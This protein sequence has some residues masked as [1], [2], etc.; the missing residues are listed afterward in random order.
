MTG[1]IASNVTSTGQVLVLFVLFLLVLLG[2]SAIGIDYAA[3]LLTDRNLQNTADHAALA[4][5]S[6]FDQ[7]ISQGSCSSGPGVA[8]CLNARAQAWTSLVNEL[9]I[10]D[11][12]GVAIGGA[13][14]G[15]L[16][17]GNSP[18]S[19]QA[20]GSYAGQPITFKDKIWVSTPPPTYDAY[21]GVGGRYALNYGVVFV[22][23]DRAVP[24]FLGGALGISPQPRHG[25]AT[26]GALPTDFALEVFCRNHIAPQSGVCVNSAGLALDGAGVMVRLRRGDIGSNESLTITSNVGS[27]VVVE[28]GNMFLVNRNCGPSTWSCPQ[29]PAVLGGI[30]DADL[31]AGPGNNKNA[32][33]IAPLPVPQFQSPLGNASNPLNDETTKATDCTGA[34]VDHLCVP[35]RPFGQ[36]SPGDWS[37]SSSDPID[38]CG[39]PVFDT[40]NGEVRCQARSSG[41]PDNHLD[42]TTGGADFNNVLGSPSQT[43]GDEYQNIDDNYAGP[44]PDTTATPADPPTDFVYVDD[45]NH[46]GAGT[47]TVTTPFTINLKQPFGV[48]NAGTSTV[49]YVAFKTDSGA[50]LAAD[51]TGYPVELT[52]ALLQGGTSIATDVQALTVD[53]TRYE[54]T[55]GA[56]VITDYNDLALRFTFVSANQ[57][58]DNPLERGGGIS[59]AE[60]ETPSLIPGSA[61]PPMIPPGYYHSITIDDDGCAILDPTAVY[62]ELY[63]Y[64]MPGI[65]RFEG[66]NSAE[67]NIG[68]GG[69]LIGDGVTLVFDSGFPAPTGGRGIIIGN[70]AVLAIN[71]SRVPGVPSCTPSETETRT[72]N[73]SDPL[74]QLSESSLCAAWAVDVKDSA[75]FKPGLPAWPHCDPAD[76]SNPQCVDRSEYS[77]TAGYR[78]VSFYFTPADWTPENGADIEDRFA[79]GGSGGATPGIAFRGVLYAPYDNVQMSGG[80][81][82]FNTVGQVLSWTAKF[83]GGCGY[84]ELDY[85][86]D[87]TPASP[88][89]LEPTVDH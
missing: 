85:P 59:W 55:V 57:A 51:P 78:G 42:P 34:S 28:S 2:V 11:D 36:G 22:R 3:W 84:I 8:K 66:D 33:Y 17:A 45:L 20:N 88:Y 54:F 67:I 64:Q 77:P 16:A 71:S 29:S 72:Y 63:Q 14:I 12:N 40:V 13:A 1:R 48:P 69:A 24:S 89:L 82:G 39:L 25:W 9:G 7:R 76:V 30:A 49:R 44:A 41:T 21:E 50:L 52:V 26:A 53:P 43:N 81:N 83:N 60:V 37:C 35:Y 31:T 62:S 79:M 61:V 38:P 10:V 18:D 75:V 46:S 47:S 56:G 6:E 65:Y 70:D 80:C 4:G 19:G 87:Y 74:A 86:Y 58:N 68:D 32:F 23:V 27:G 5:A 73:P 15:A